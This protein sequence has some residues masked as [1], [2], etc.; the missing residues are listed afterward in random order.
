M[1]HLYK[2]SMAWHPLT[3]H[4]EILEHLLTCG[5]AILNGNSIDCT[6]WN[7]TRQFHFLCVKHEESSIRHMSHVQLCMIHRWTRCDSSS[8]EA[9]QYDMLSPQYSSW[10]PLCLFL[11]SA[12]KKLLLSRGRR[13]DSGL[14]VM[15]CVSARLEFFIWMVKYSI[16]HQI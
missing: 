8:I 15:V 16:S 12:L 5:C 14:M 6:T 11:S 2:T 4:H 9:F 13:N 10:N 1:I 3:P 7:T